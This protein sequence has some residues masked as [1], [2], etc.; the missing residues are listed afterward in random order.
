MTRGCQWLIKT[1]DISRPKCAVFDKFIQLQIQVTV[2]F[3]KK[4]SPRKVH[5]KSILVRVAFN[6][7]TTFPWC[8]SWRRFL[9]AAYEVKS[10][11]RNGA[12]TCS[13][14]QRFCCYSR[15]AFR[16]WWCR[17]SHLDYGW[18]AA[19]SAQSVGHGPLVLKWC[20]FIAVESLQAFVTAQLANVDFRTVCVKQTW[21][22]RLANRVKR[23][24]HDIKYWEVL[25]FTLTS[26][27]FLRLSFPAGTL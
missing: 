4:R 15:A 26:H 27:S 18:T 1:F 7:A 14:K 5:S 25:S 12:D 13:W 21:N 11:T 3:A 8:W 9:R 6:N 23:M 20:C 2:G 24:W 19:L 10:A 17:R 16:S 22:T